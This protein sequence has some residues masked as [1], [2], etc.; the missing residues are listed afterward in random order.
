MHAGDLAGEPGRLRA[1][2]AVLLQREGFELTNTIG[3]D[4]IVGDPALV[5]GGPAFRWPGGVALTGR[6]LPDGGRMSVRVEFDPEQAQ[7]HAGRVQ[8]YVSNRGAQT[9]TVDLAGSGDGSCFFVTPATV[10]FGSTT[11]AAAS[12]PRARTRSTNALTM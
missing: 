2:E 12:A 8:F 10:D 9:T 6:T 4:C 1:G 11:Q 5:T 7:P 3:D